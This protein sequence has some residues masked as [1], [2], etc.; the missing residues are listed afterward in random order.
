[1][2]VPGVVAA[3]CSLCPGGES[4]SNREGLV[5][6]FPEFDG[7]EVISCHDLEILALEQKEEGTPDCDRIQSIEVATTCGC[8]LRTTRSGNS[9]TLCLDGSSVGRPDRNVPSFQSLFPSNITTCSLLEQ[10]LFTQ[11]ITQTDAQCLGVSSNLRAYCGCPDEINQRDDDDDNCSLCGD[12]ENLQSDKVI[13]LFN[14]ETCLEFDDALR[15]L[16]PEDSTRCQ[17]MKSIRG[18]CCGVQKQQ[19]QQ[20]HSAVCTLCPDGTSPLPNRA[21]PFVYSELMGESSNM[22][23]GLYQDSLQ[24][25]SIDECRLA[26]EGVASWCGCPSTGSEV[27]NKC[28]ICARSTSSQYRKKE[29]ESLK[30]YQTVVINPN[31]D[32]VAE[33]LSLRVESQSRQ[34]LDLQQHCGCVGNQ[35]TTPQQQK[36][37]AWIPKITA[38]LSILGALAIILDIRRS[39]KRRKRVYCRVVLLKSMSEMVYAFCWFIGS[40]GSSGSNSLCQFQAFFFQLGQTACVLCN[41]CLAVYY[42]LVVHFDMKERT[43]QKIQKWFRGIPLVCGLVFAFGGLPF[44]DYWGTSHLICHVEPFPIEENLGPVIVLLYFPICVSMTILV[45][46]FGWI[47]YSLH[48]KAASRYAKSENC[49]KLTRLVF[50]QSTW[51][52]LCFSLTWPALLSGWVTSGRDGSLPF[53][54]VLLIALVAPLQGFVSAV[55]YFKPRRTSWYQAAVDEYSSETNEMWNSTNNMWNSIAHSVRHKGNQASW[56]SFATAVTAKAGNKL[57]RGA[58]QWNKESG[59]NESSQKTTAHQSAPRLLERSSFN[60][61]DALFRVIAP[62]A[63][64]ERAST[65]C[66]YIFESEPSCGLVLDGVM[67]DGEGDG[68][69]ASSRMNELTWNGDLETGENTPSTSGQQASAEVPIMTSRPIRDR[70]DPSSRPQSN[71]RDLSSQESESEKKETADYVGR[72]DYMLPLP[73]LEKDDEVP[74]RVNQ[75]KGKLFTEDNKLSQ[76]VTLDQINDALSLNV[77]E[78]QPRRNSCGGLS[79]DSCQY[80]TKPLKDAFESQSL[81]SSYQYDGRL[82][83]KDSRE[84]STAVV[85]SDRQQRRKDSL[86]DTS[87]SHSSGYYRAHQFH[88]TSSNRHRRGSFGSTPPDFLDL[89][90]SSIRSQE[91]GQGPPVLHSKQTDGILDN[92]V[93]E[94]SFQ[95]SLGFLM[96]DS[97]GN[98]KTARP[99]LSKE[100]HCESMHFSALFNKTDSP[101]EDDHSEFECVRNKRKLKSARKI[102]ELLDPAIILAFDEEDEES[103]KGMNIDLSIASTVDSSKRRKG[104]FA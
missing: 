29:L 58:Q 88:G 32:F 51:N 61:N 24:T 47:A 25:V 17:Q 37:A 70:K 101:S 9:C 80:T 49:A 104:L 72:Y 4:V 7:A 57:R 16:L 74:T 73:P 19:Q 102:L 78:A 90:D 14:F 83:R 84:S 33:S 103:F 96:E 30:D 85:S 44:Y 28:E 63:N 99:T 100:T 68:D 41:V 56:G 48:A 55:I 27:E 64:T 31:C 97:T 2:P 62:Q 11:H 52:V 53:S 39:K 12:D 1:M 91:E 65:R 59:T 8:P 98:S 20:Q 94:S 77:S 86:G 38:S 18:I 92:S 71:S 36:A 23:C 81:A 45:A 89:A 95:I 13:H 75:S 54:L 46:V 6:D 40:W 42:L 3:P 87:G 50:W 79:V 22:T 15:Y 93:A 60:E 69:G 76:K 66:S 67:P 82:R 21:I 5:Y 35:A 43:L 34:C 10:Y 26:Q